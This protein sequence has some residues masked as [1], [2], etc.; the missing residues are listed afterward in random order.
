MT[1]ELLEKVLVCNR[2]TNMFADVGLRES[3]T[4]GG[5]LYTYFRSRLFLSV[6]SNIELIFMMHRI[7]SQHKN[8]S[9]AKKKIQFIKRLDFIIVIVEQ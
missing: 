9:Q 8:N 5:N 3:F 1:K 2:G 6:L 7:H 4:F